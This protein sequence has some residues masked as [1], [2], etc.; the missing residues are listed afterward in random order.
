MN[1]SV[2][3][4]GVIVSLA[5][6]Q[7]DGRAPIVP[8]MHHVGRDIVI[9]EPDARSPNGVRESRLVALERKLRDPYASSTIYE[10]PHHVLT[11]VAIQS[12]QNCSCYKPM[13]RS[14]E[15]GSFAR[16]SSRARPGVS[17]VIHRWRYPAS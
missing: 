14:C 1:A 7:V 13:T 2:P 10:R 12:P 17:S 11:V 9:P 15:L 3:S 6:I 4:S 5:R 8:P 16:C